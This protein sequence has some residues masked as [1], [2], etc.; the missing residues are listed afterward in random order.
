VD[1][2]QE[3]WLAAIRGLRTLRDPA[4]FPAWIYGIAH[5]KCVD[6]LRARRR[7]RALVLDA[8]PATTVDAGEAD[9]ER[10]LDLAA[11]MARLDD[12]HRAVVQLFYGEDL[13][14]NEIATVLS[15]PAGTV[16]SRLFHARLQ[17]RK[18]LGE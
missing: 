7:A 14:M 1:I 2:I 9:P 18:L 15:V 12:G 13:G 4:S 3:T 11:A 5:R 10:R 6:T 16:K 8:G 17:L